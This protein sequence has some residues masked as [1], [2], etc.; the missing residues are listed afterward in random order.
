[1]I[2]LSTMSGLPI[3]KDDQFHLVFQD[4][5]PKVEAAVRTIEQ[6]KDVLLDKSLKEPKELYY[7]YRD[8][9]FDKDRDAEKKNQLR[10]DITI[11]KPDMLGKELMK[12]AGHYHPGNYPELYEVISGEA[13]CIQQKPSK[14]DYKKIEDVIWVKAKTG[15]KIICLPGYGHILINPSKTESLI[16][17]NWVGT[18]FSSDYSLYKEGQGA[19][20]LFIEET[21]KLK[22]EK[23][24]FF[25]E[26][27]AIRKVVP[28]AKI[29]RFGL[30]SGKPI[31]PLINS[32][33]RLRFLN[34]PEEF[35]YSD[36][37][38]KA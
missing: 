28:G 32:P 33:E 19:A 14:D 26:V 15:D 31:Y 5:L 38:R 3:K 27:V 22:I 10:Y 35:D 25:T 16:T 12:T 34:Y 18:K 36:A 7:M 30:E 11:I 1:M 6:M 24:K 21:G 29:E 4:G 37:F 23:N 17:S 8:V 2:D 13:W 9:A 20:Y